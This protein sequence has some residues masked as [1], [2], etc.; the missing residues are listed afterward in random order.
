MTKETH[1]EEAV[2]A[3]LRAPEPAM[4]GPTRLRKRKGRP[5]AP[6]FNHGNSITLLHQSERGNTAS[7]SGPDHDE[8]E[9]ELRAASCHTTPPTLTGRKMRRY[10]TRYL[11]ASMTFWAIP[12]RSATVL[13]GSYLH[14]RRRIAS[15]DRSISPSAHAAMTVLAALSIFSMAPEI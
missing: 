6:H 12:C 3:K 11:P 10:A 4:Y 7:E 14:S 9:I 2:Q 15:C 8:V 1:I 5:A 13:N